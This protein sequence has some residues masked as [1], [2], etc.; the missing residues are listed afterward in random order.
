M[1]KAN[2]NKAKF[3]IPAAK[4][5]WSLALKRK[6]VLRELSRISARVHEQTD[7]KLVFHNSDWKSEEASSV[8]LEHGFSML[9]NSLD[10]QETP[11]VLIRAVNIRALLRHLYREVSWG[12]E[13]HH[14]RSMGNSIMTSS[15]PPESHLDPLQRVEL[16]SSG[17]SSGYLCHSISLLCAFPLHSH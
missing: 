10:R 8:I 2:G 11:S 15:S 9:R 12:Q 14:A 7:Q 13:H 17:Y 4:N 5:L 6:W 1:S 16:C 3:N